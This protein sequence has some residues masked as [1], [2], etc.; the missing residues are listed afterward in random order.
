MWSVSL[1]CRH[2][3]AVVIPHSPCGNQNC[4]IFVIQW[5]KAWCSLRSTHSAG[6][7][8]LQKL[9]T[10]ITCLSFTGLTQDIC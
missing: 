10:P 7:I 8:L 1:H 6:L 4:F 9:P 5:E 2:L 3:T